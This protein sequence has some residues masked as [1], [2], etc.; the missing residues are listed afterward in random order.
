[1][2][3]LL[4]LFATFTFASALSFLSQPSVKI[5]NGTVL[6]YRLAGVDSFKGIPFAQP[7]VGQ[8]RLRTPQPLNQSFGTFSATNTMPQMC[9]QFDA[10]L[11]VPSP[12]PQVFLDI[13]NSEP[14]SNLTNQGEDC[15]TLNVQRPANTTGNSKLPVVIW[16]Y[17]GGFE[18]GSTI[19]SPTNDA[20]AIINRAVAL[21]APVVYVSMNY[22]LSHFGFLGGKEVQAAGISNLGLLDQR[23]AM[24][25]VQ[26]NIAAF[27]GDP[28]KVTIW[29]ESAG[30]LSVLDH[31]IA[32]NGDNTYHGKPL[33][34][35]A[36]LD[37]GSMLPAESISSARAQDVFNRVVTAGGCDNS[38][39]ILACLRSLP[40]EKF[41]LAGQVVPSA[42]GYQ[43]V[44]VYYLPRP[45]N[46]SN[47]YPQSADQAIYAG[48][49]A[50]VPVLIGN[51]QDE[52]TLPALFPYNITNNEQVVEY[53]KLYFPQAPNGT[54]QRL[55]NVYP[56]NP[57]DGAP[58]NTGDLNNW[59][60]EFKRIAAIIGDLYYIL[61]RRVY[62]ESVS[63]TIPAWSYLSTYDHLTSILGTTHG[64][65]LS[66]IYGAVQTAPLQPSPLDYFIS[67]VNHF[68]P[69][70]LFPQQ[71]FPKYCNVTKQMLSFN[72]GSNSVITDDFRT[73][74][75]KV[76][77]EVF[78]MLLH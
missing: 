2:W 43:S 59:Y 33:F 76:F 46:S 34:H 40:Y 27:G 3:S 53:L 67:F 4:T 31:L 22:R 15:L 16:I 49:Y 52:G 55:V 66:V 8:L 29:G 24:K 48:D 78:S 45:D 74:Q 64:S 7:P 14:V 6:G 62:L 10:P 30:S 71:N 51:Q 11:D 13:I 77:K 72:N 35:G 1:M 47:F 9:P 73:E 69:N 18:G 75:Y 37:S 63:E 60:P 12:T 70:G 42:S 50:K 26:D 39:D 58:Y 21:N 19:S 36:I 25:W 61:V 68:D 32:K 41:K 20:T 54:V 56:D 5:T 65:D 17:G 44:N 23:L 38:T 57:A 28:R